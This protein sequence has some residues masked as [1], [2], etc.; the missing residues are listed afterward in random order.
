M[1]VDGKRAG[2]Q[3]EFWLVVLIAFQRDRIDCGAPSRSA[4]GKAGG[5]SQSTVVVVGEESGRRG[6]A[7]RIWTG[8][9]TLRRA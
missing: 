3:V 8:C 5:H 7:A 9:G 2:R 6:A 4:E 1:C